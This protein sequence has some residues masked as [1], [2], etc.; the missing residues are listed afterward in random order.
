MVWATINWHCYIWLTWSNTHDGRKWLDLIPRPAWVQGKRDI[1]GTIAELV[2]AVSRRK[3]EFAEGPVLTN[4]G[5]PHTVA[6][7]S[8]FLFASRK[9]LWVIIGKKIKKQQSDSH[10]GLF[11]FLSSAPFEE[12]LTNYLFIK[13]QIVK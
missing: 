11:T 9:E 5:Y 3:E 6:V 7:S 13:T 2:S 8:P 10:L 12:E 1:V 4:H